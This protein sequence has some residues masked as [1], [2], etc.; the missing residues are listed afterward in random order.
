MHMM[1]SVAHA[2]D[3]EWS[4]CMRC[5]SSTL[6]GWGL[7][8]GRPCCSRGEGLLNGRPHMWSGVH[9]VWTVGCACVG[10]QYG[11]PEAGKGD[12]CSELGDY[13]PPRV[14]WGYVVYVV[15]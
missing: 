13:L 6:R 15:C 14:G 5:G 3:V 2:Y 9:D 10:V 11:E 8:S 12:T 1:R 4:E 7:G